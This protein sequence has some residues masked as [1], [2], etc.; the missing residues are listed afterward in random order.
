[1]PVKEK[2]VKPA[3]TEAQKLVAIKFLWCLNVK[4]RDKMYGGTVSRE[5]KLKRRSLNGRQ[6]QSRRANR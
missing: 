2:Y 1:M 6:K 3:L 5:T 4:M